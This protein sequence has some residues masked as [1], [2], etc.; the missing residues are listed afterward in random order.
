MH[1]KRPKN[2]FF[3]PIE[4]VCVQNMYVI[5]I[6]YSHEFKIGKSILQNLSI[7]LFWNASDML[8]IIYIY[9]KNPTKSK[10]S[11]NQHITTFI[12]IY[13]QKLWTFSI[14]W[15]KKITL[16]Y[17]FVQCSSHIHSYFRFEIT[18]KNLYVGQCNTDLYRMV[19]KF[20]ASIQSIQSNSLH[21][22]RYM[23][24]KIYCFISY[25]SCPLK[26]T[27]YFYMSFWL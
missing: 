15:K 16:Y 20:I 9:Q 7:R 8:N 19:F 24:S 17:V 11:K 2:F 10:Y 1:L 21:N 23:D 18:R 12:P 5:F 25:K 22:I 6:V 14:S 26:H 3:P 4:G 13:M 27:S